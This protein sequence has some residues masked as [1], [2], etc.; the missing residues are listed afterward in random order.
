MNRSLRW[1]MIAIPTAWA[2]AGIVALAARNPFA[3]MVALVA[4]AMVFFIE[5]ARAVR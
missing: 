3:L 1:K 2:V 4:T 5:D